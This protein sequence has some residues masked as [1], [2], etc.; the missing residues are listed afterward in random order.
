M[1]ASGRPEPTSGWCADMRE[2]GDIPFST[3]VGV[4]RHPRESDEPTRE[5]T[6][7]VDAAVTDVSDTDPLGVLV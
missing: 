7:F 2:I 1:P 5:P 6:V 4:S 3:R